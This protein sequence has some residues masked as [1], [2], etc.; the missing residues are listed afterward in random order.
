MYTAS[1][2]FDAPNTFNKSIIVPVSLTV[3]P[4]GGGGPQY[5]VSTIAGNGKST[6]TSGSGNAVDTALGGTSAVAFDNGGHLLISGGNRIWQLNGTA[7]TSIAGSGVMG[8]TGDGGPATQALVNDPGAI[9]VDKQGNIYLSEITPAKVRRI[10]SGTVS[11]W[12]DTPKF[13]FQGSHG[14][15]FDSNGLLVLFNYTSLVH[16]SGGLIN[17]TTGFSQP[18]GVAADAAGNF[19]ISDQGSNRIYKR[20]TDGS[21]TV[22][23]GTG[24]AGFSG[25]GG[26]ATQAQL[27]NPAGLAVDSKGAVYFADSTNQRVRMI[28]PDGIIRTIAGSGLSGFAGDGSSGDFAEFANPAG[29]AVDAQGNV[30]VADKGNARVRKLSPHAPQ[31]A[32]LL[33]WASGVAK[34]SPGS[35]FSVYGTVLAGAP[36]STNT[37]P[38]PLVL[39]DVRVTINGILAPLA[40]VS[41]IQLNGQIPYEISPGQATAIITVNGVP[42]QPI[43]FTVL[44][45]Y[46]GIPVFAGN[47]ALAVNAFD[48]N[49]NTTDTPA[50]PLDVEIL[51]F[52]GIGIPDHPVDTARASRPRA[53]GTREVSVLD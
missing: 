6:N 18:Y 21:V 30:Y 31:P 12:V 45:A 2:K 16:F 1:I 8:S 20:T 43:T 24:S 14:L 17:V 38:W 50:K 9:A 48:G 39:A 41:P 29:V 36:A 3:V 25:D 10:V 27:N 52:S 40:Y 11:V 22:L 51:Y 44:D 13:Q 15:A 33:H 34:L 47:R 53:T 32:A 26:P 35:L 23:A 19:Y 42:G 49:V 37:V 7:I 5:T 28:T 46:P 4:V